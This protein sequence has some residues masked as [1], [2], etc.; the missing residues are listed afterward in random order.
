[1]FPE[2]DFPILLPEAPKLEILDVS[3]APVLCQRSHPVGLP[4]LRAL[5]VSNLRV[6]DALLWDTLSLAPRLDSLV[7]RHK[8]ERDLPNYATLRP[9]S[10][11]ISRLEVDEDVYFPVGGI[12]YP[13]LRSLRS[14]NMVHPGTMARTVTTVELESIFILDVDQLRLFRVVEHVSLRGFDSPEQDID[15][16][17]LFT[18]LLDPA[19]SMWPCLR[20]LELWNFESEVECGG[21]LDVVRARNVPPKRPGV[22]TVT[23]R[24]LENV[25]FD[26]ISVPGWVAAQLREILGDGCAVKMPDTRYLP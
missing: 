12:D 9:P 3:G 15:L 2:R 6:Y 18:A 24:P 26:T 7:L 11:P 4:A 19:E 8:T 25:E 17:E 5:T 10:L 13:N 21:L 16:Q 1:M 23:P 14:W 22:S 20:H